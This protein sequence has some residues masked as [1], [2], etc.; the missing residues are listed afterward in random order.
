MAVGLH[1]LTAASNGNG[2]ATKMVEHRFGN[3]NRRFS[4][5]I[6]ITGTFDSATVTLEGSHDNSTWVAITD[7]SW[8]AAAVTNIEFYG[9]WLRGVVASG[10]G[11][12]SITMVLV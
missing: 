5:T 4:Y 3:V 10:S 7:A 1:L 2:T 11:S 6:Y 12:E 9:T 8:T